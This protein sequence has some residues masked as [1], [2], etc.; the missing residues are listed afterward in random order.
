MELD[1]ASKA[2]LKLLYPDLSIR[3]IR[4]LRDVRRIL[5]LQMRV[6][7]AL[8]TMDAQAALYAS[9]RTAPGPILTNAKPGESMH[10]YG[11]ALDFC[12]RGP[13]PYLTKDKNAD[14]IWRKFGEI[15][16]GYGF[17]WGGDWNGNGQVEKNDFDKPHIQLTYGLREDYIR[18]LAQFKGIPSVWAAFDKIRGV[19]QSREWAEL[20]A[21]GRLI[22]LGKRLV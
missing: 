5:G 2:R 14:Y 9:G 16:R 6:T 17:D 1:A 15:A 18:E 21:S 8:R 3:V 13:D 20:A 4:L 22:E 7:E 12:F 19:E 10:H 11:C